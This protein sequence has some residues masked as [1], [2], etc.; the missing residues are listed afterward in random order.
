MCSCKHKRSLGEVCSRCRLIRGLAGKFRVVE[1]C[2]QRYMVSFPEPPV[3]SAVLVSDCHQGGG[4]TVLHIQEG[5]KVDARA[6]E[7]DLEE[8]VYMA[9]V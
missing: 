8:I 3:H 5:Y 4:L 7:A 9:V 2:V 6:W 1:Q